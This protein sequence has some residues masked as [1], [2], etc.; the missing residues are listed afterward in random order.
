MAVPL[1]AAGAARLFA[2]EPRDAGLS[3]AGRGYREHTSAIPNKAGAVG[4]L[5]DETELALLR[6]TKPIALQVYPNWA[7]NVV[8]VRPGPHVDTITGRDGVAFWFNPVEQHRYSVNVMAT[9]HLHAAADLPA[10]Q[11]P[12]LYGPVLV[13]G[14]DDTGEPAGLSHEQ[15]QWLADDRH[16]GKWAEWTLRFRTRRE[17]RV[18][19]GPG[20][21]RRDH[22]RLGALP[23]SANGHCELTRRSPM[24]AALV[25]SGCSGNGR[26]DRLGGPR[27]S[28]AA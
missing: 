19:A 24:P 2:G 23:D 16:F 20:V 28:V 5:F 8:A 15:I 21:A 13:A 18:G 7:M 14:H 1:A 10:R 9:L 27:S 26:G 22:A 25:L 6:S 12:L 17:A 4:E 3:A 11:V